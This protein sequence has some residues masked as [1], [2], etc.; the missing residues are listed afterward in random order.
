MQKRM[1]YSQNFIKN[2]KLV[3]DLISRS[4]ISKNDIIFDIGAGHGIITKELLDIGC[5]VKAFEIDNNLYKRLVEK[6][7]SESSLELILGNFLKFNLPSYPYKVFSNIPFNITSSVIKKLTNS[8]N[9]P[10]DT[11]LIVQKEVAIRFIGKPFDS[12]NS[13]ISILLKPWFESTVLHKFSRS[14]FFP[15][16][17]IDVVLMRIEKKYK[18]LVNIENKQLYYDFIAYTYNQRKSNISKGLS[19]VIR[20]EDLINLSKQLKFSLNSKP[21]DMSLTSWLGIFDHILNNS[22]ESQKKIIKDYFLKLSVLQEKLIKNNRTR[23]D[24]D[25]RIK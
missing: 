25:W 2:K 5:K 3:S 14:D 15:K 16:P 13:Q 18:P 22:S 23:S 8:I 11:Y 24:K 1:Y 4:S 10:L 19:K 6:Y 20:N 17:N 9:P 12:K 21:S 7:K